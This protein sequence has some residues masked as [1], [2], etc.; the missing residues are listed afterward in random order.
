MPK[1]GYFNKTSDVRHYGSNIALKQSE[2][3]SRYH[4]G[5]KTPQGRMRNKINAKNCGAW[6][7]TEQESIQFAL[8]IPECVG[9]TRNESTNAVYFT[10]NTGK[11]K[12]QESKWRCKW[13]LYEL[14][15]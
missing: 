5:F 4:K 9:F 10:R 8:Q 12:F 13:S 15:K 2:Y 6:Y 7:G 3:A 14:M 11:Q 1:I